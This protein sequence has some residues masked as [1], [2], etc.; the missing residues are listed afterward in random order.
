MS[1]RLIVFFDDFGELGVLHAYNFLT[2]V[3]AYNAR[4]LYLK[5]AML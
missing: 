2:N 3:I 1:G 4:I 5:K